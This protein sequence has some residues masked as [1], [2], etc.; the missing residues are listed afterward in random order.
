M[1]RLSRKELEKLPTIFAPEGTAL[2]E[3]T[4]AAGLPWAVEEC[5]ERAK[6]DL[7]LDHYVVKFADGFQANVS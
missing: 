6:D 3:L 2:A 1:I 5:F 7:G 4:G